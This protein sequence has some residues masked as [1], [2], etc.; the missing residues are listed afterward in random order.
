M[1]GIAGQIG[2]PIGQD[3][4]AELHQRMAGRGPDQNGY[5]S[6]AV[7]T[8]VHARLAVIDLE[9]GV[10]PMSLG[11]KVIVYN[12]EIY[13]TSEVR[14]ELAAR[15]RR[16]EG[17]SDTEVVL[18]AYDE[19]GEDCLQRLNGIFAFAVWDGA[20]LFA[21]RDRMGVKPFF[22][23]ERDGLFCF[24]SEIKG[25]LAFPHMN[26]ELDWDGICEVMLLGPGRTPG[27]GVFRGICELP[28]AHCGYY[29]PGRGF[30][31]RQYWSIRER[32]HTESFEE[33]VEH[34]RFLVTDSIE[35][36]LI[37]DVP[38]CTFL[39]G[40]L[41]SSLISSVAARRAKTA[42]KRLSTVSVTY[43]DNEKYFQ[44]GHFQPNSDE[45]YIRMMSEYLDSDHHLIEIDSPELADALYDAVEARDLPGM[46]D[47]D[48]SLLL[49][50]REIKKIG[51]VALSGEC[52]DE[53][54]GGYPW[55]RDKDIRMTDGF[56]WA[57][58]T[59][60][61]AGFLREELAQHIDA[62]AY[63]Y[64]KYR[65]T[66][67]TVQKP[68]Y[69]SETDRRMREMTRLNLDW[70]MQT[71][72]EALDL[73]KN[74]KS[75]IRHSQNLHNPFVDIHQDGGYNVRHQTNKRR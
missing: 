32:K 9:G 47:V 26:A 25:V 10:Q 49:F 36:Q 11:D 14:A 29:E 12:G 6:D 18:H 37:S 58:S 34:V 28:P 39:S 59:A 41:D 44:A 60:Y 68:A 50:C 57:Q 15:G 1:C 38:V 16:F 61:R 62:Q 66:I 52:A 7:C 45:R 42:G 63:V 8:L 75:L 71:L 69:L 17:H 65:N 24:A 48:S 2:A 27:C 23:S 46:A 70:F 56:P 31:C 54:F 13:N 40:G 67:E 64:Q 22:Y 35:R 51:T 5:W 30:S 19:W 33:T 43:K 53:I 20:R 73:W 55:Y 21:A 3:T 4:I 72:L 74:D